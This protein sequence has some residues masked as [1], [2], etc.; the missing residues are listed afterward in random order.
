MTE[1]F[2]EVRRERGE[3]LGLWTRRA[4]LALLVAVAALAVWGVFGQRDRESTVTAN[5]VTM[6]V[7]SPDVVRGGLYFQATVDITTTVDIEHPRLV[8]DEGWVEG[9]QVNSIEPAAESESSRDGRVVLSYGA[10]EPGDILRVWMQFE[11][12]PTNVGKRSFGLE[13]DDEERPLARIPHTLRVL[14]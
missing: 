2:T 13:L 4:I 3:E 7:S 10:L 9:L 11:V 14:P 6:T 12:N 5:G 8:L 1:L